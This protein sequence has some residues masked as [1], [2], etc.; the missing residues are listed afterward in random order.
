MS[1][2]APGKA[3][4]PRKGKS[5]PEISFSHR[6]PSRGTGY[7]HLRSSLPEEPAMGVI[8]WHVRTRRGVELPALA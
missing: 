1:G 8:T 7:P 2:Q 3:Q 5:P 6:D 4:R